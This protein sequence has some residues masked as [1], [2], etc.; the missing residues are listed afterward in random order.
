MRSIKNIREK[1]TSVEGLVVGR[2]YVLYNRIDDKRLLFK[3]KENIGSNVYDSLC[4]IY[5]CSMYDNDN[6]MT[7]KFEDGKFCLRATKGEVKEYF[8]EVI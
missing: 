7:F 2:W 5:W 8:K 3:F 4:Y 1:I 6:G